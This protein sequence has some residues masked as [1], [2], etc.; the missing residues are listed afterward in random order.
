MF[1][2]AKMSSSKDTTLVFGELDQDQQLLLQNHKV[3]TVFVSKT[4]ME[5]NPRN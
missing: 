3:A 5:E 4:T 2:S 1:S